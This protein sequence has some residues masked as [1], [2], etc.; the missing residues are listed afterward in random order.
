MVGIQHLAY[1]CQFRHVA[2]VYHRDVKPSNI[3]I[4]SDCKVKLCDFSLARPVFNRSE[5]LQSEWTGYVATRWCAGRYVHAEG[6]CLQVGCCG[7]RSPPRLLCCLRY[8]PPEMCL[9]KFTTWAQ[10]MDTWG[11][12][13]VF[14]E[15]LLGQP[16]FPGNNAEEQLSLIT[17][18]LG[19][20]PPLVLGKVTAMAWSVQQLDVAL[21]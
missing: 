11:I 13:C 14:M 1:T 6:V 4:N 10:A 15:A 9:A 18:L 7:L 2:H 8:R 3:L 12:G 17:D 21:A 19:T 20:P 16:L 5:V